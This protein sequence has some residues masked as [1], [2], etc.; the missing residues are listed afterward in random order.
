[1]LDFQQYQAQFTAYIR[2]PIHN[3]K[4]LKVN[5]SRLAVYKKAVFN[6]IVDSVSVCF[7]VCQTVIGK[8]AWQKLM[9]EFVATY[10]AASPIFREIP[11][12]FLLFL[13]N[14]ETVPAYFKQLAHYEW[15]ELAVS[16]QQSKQTILSDLTDFLHEK[17]MIAAAHMLLEYDYPV[18]QISAKFKPKQPKKT[19]LLVFRN[20]EYQVKFIEL[21]PITYRLLQLIDFENLSGEQALTQLAQEIEHPEIA[22]II[23]FGSAI[24][25]DLFNQQAIIGSQKLISV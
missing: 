7:P 19:T 20:P 18:H 12:Q 13:D 6:N 21:N 22:V 3:K 17:P 14:V 24:L 25:I 8:R 2:N 23:E 16:K 1:M 5:A 15:V 9:R 4:P 11:Q 10:A